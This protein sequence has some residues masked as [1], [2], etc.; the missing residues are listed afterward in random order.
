MATDPTDSAPNDDADG[1]VSFMD[2]DS[3]EEVELVSID[4]PPEEAGPLLERG[5]LPGCLL[6][7]IRMS[8]F[9]DPVVS[10]DGMCFALRKET[11]A[12]LRVRS[13]EDAA[14]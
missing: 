3:T 13:V 5:I 7:R 8:P 9:G 1:C 11:A 10:A 12:C 4:L 2:V 14:S 6:C